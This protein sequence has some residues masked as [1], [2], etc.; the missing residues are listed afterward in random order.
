MTA[1]RWN[2]STFEACA[3]LPVT[4]R[5]FRYGMALFE[6]IRIRRARA[7]FLDEHLD[8]LRAACA[9]RA[10]PLSEPALAPVASR[11][12]RQAE[13]PARLYVTAGDGA[14]FADQASE[15]RIVVLCEARPDPV[16]ELC[17]LA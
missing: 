1:W 13:G 2:G 4:D 8:L 11:R 6:S 12:A 17:S 3:S 16:A 10:F 5:G 14:H 9:D 15:P 7:L